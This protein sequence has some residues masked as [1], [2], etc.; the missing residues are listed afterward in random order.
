MTI[1]EKRKVEEGE[2]YEDC[3]EK[4]EKLYLEHK[5]KFGENLLSEVIYL[6]SHARLISEKRI[7]DKPKELYEKALKICE[8]KLPNHPERVA[9]LLF[10]GRNAKRRNEYE[11]AEEQLN[12]ALDLSMNCLGEHVMTA[13]CFKDIADLLFFVKRKVPK[14]E[15]GFDTVLSY[16]EKS[17]EMLE[18]LGMDGHKETILTLKNCGSCHSSNGNYEK[19]RK[20]LE[21]AERVAERELENDHRWKV[22]VK[23]QQALV[24][25]KENREDQMIEAMK[26][27]LKMCYKLG[28]TIEDLGNKHEIRKVLHRHPNKFPKDEY[29]C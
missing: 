12:Q 4:A 29:P 8:Q 16:Y 20:I 11:Q 6:H 23:T 28:K 27:G 17:L 1:R 2:E 22:M 13:Q 24:F 5:M 3:M 14:G 7:P 9:T 18:H 15:R 19:A 26:S 10:A 25:D 21:R